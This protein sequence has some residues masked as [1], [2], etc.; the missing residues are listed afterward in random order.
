MQIRLTL[1]SALVSLTAVL[2][3]AC[4]GGQDGVLGLSVGDCFDDVAGLDSEY[5]V[6]TPAIATV[7]CDVAHDNELYVVLDLPD[8]EWTE[9]IADPLFDECDGQYEDY[10][11]TP[12]DDSSLDFEMIV[13]D[14]EAWDAGERASGCYLYAF[15]PDDGPLTESVKGSGR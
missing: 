13:P 4:T 12:Y 9:T 8:G 14:Q 11:G 2:A 10:V 6:D 5:S 3:V 7:D 15:F 1:R